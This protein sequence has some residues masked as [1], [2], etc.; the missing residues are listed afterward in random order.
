MEIVPL[1]GA[2]SHQVARGDI[3]PL[4]PKGS[5]NDNARSRVKFPPPAPRAWSVELTS[6][7]PSSTT[8]A[9]PCHIQA[10]GRIGTQIQRVD[11]QQRTRHDVH[12][13]INDRIALD[14]FHGNKRI[15]HE[16]QDRAD[17][18]KDVNKDVKGHKYLL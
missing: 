1:I 13:L 11:N 17:P 12:A 2:C 7:K 14:L 6:C 18:A 10:R 9:D 15:R 5:S 3:C 4:F 8:D 16:I